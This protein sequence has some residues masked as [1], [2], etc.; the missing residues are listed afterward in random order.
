MVPLVQGEGQTIPNNPQPPSRDY[1][2]QDGGSD[3]RFFE[4]RSMWLEGYQIVNISEIEKVVELARRHNYNCLSPLIN[5]DYYGVYYNSKYEP[6]HVDVAWNFDPLMELIQE[7]HKYGIAVMPWFHTMINPIALRDNPEWGAVHESGYRSIYWMNPALPQVK[8][9]LGNTTRELF[10][11]Y[12]LDGIKI[13]TIRYPNGQYSYDDYSLRIYVDEG[14]DD[15][16]AFRREQITKIMK[17]INGN[18]TEMRPWAWIGADIFSN[19]NSR[20]YGVFQDAYGWSRDGLIDFATPMIYTTSVS[21]YR[22]TLEHNIQTLLCP[23][24]GGTYVYVPGNSAHGYVPDE[25][26]G[27]SILENQTRAARD[28]DALGTC[29]FAYKFLRQNITYPRALSGSVFSDEA[30]CPLKEQEHPVDTTRWDFDNDHDREGWRT[31]NM[32]HFYPSEEVWSVS[33]VKA[34]TFMTPLMN[35]SAPGTNVI[36]ISMKTESDGGEVE[37]YWSPVNTNFSETRRINFTLESDGDWNLYSIHLDRSRNW[38]GLIKY[39]MIRP[40]F[41]ERTNLT[42]DFI[43]LTWMPDCIQSVSYLGPFTTGN[44]SSLMTT[45]FVGGEEDLDPLKDQVVG[46]RAWRLYD[47]GRDRIDMRFPLG[48]LSYSVTY[49]HLFLLAS[50]TRILEARTGSSDGMIM[51]INGEEVVRNSQPRRVAPDQNTTRVRIDEGINRVLVKLCVYENDNSVFMRFTEPG[52]IT[53]EG[54]VYIPDAKPPD[55]PRIGGYSDTWDRDGDL[56]ISLDNPQSVIPF[57]RYQWRIDMA[58]LNDLSEKQLHLNDLETGVHLLEVRSVNSLGIHSNFSSCEIFVDRVVPV[59]T[60]PEPEKER[61]IGGAISWNW[62]LERNPPSGI[63]QMEF[64]VMYRL[65]EDDPYSERVYYSKHY[66]D[67]FVLSDNLRDGFTYQL[68]VNIETNSGNS[69]SVRSVTKTLVDTCPPR[70]T[71]NPEILLTDPENRVYRVTWD[72][73]FDDVDGVVKCYQVWTRRSGDY[74]RYHTT[75]SLAEVEVVRPLY[76]ILDVKIRAVDKGGLN[77]MFSDTVTTPLVK[78]DPVIDIEGMTIEGYPLE[79]RSRR[80]SDPDG[81]ITSTKWYLNGRWISSD[82]SVMLNLPKGN[83]TISLRVEDDHGLSEN[84]SRVL[85]VGCSGDEPYNGSLRTYLNEK[86][87]KDEYLPPQEVYHYHNVTIPT[88]EETGF[89]REGGPAKVAVMSLVSI[90]IVMISALALLLLLVFIRSESLHEKDGVKEDESGRGPSKI[91]QYSKQKSSGLRY[92]GKGRKRSELSPSRNDNEEEPV[93]WE[94]VN[95]EDEEVDF[96]L[97]EDDIR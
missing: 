73:V 72:Y 27:I 3:E 7:A 93:E 12:P 78:P 82:P 81:I 6:K 77:G 69:Y 51:W 96:V 1:P 84:V 25:E 62:E 5:G 19:Y 24:V 18:I 58:G 10:Y 30:L 86:H 22:A 83:H 76:S 67:S 79:I 17:V 15:P 40:L 68:R 55:P 34:P 48:P 42:L 91:P 90:A 46:G 50:D 33:N 53:A 85:T 8:N 88:E 37:I 28:L 95:V 32:G 70:K 47:M 89:L 44:G 31:T 60:A 43:E 9:Y 11:R 75:V 87:V 49:L 64:T 23:V 2:Q 94:E 39:I 45:D 21:S 66:R 71:T 16:D 57:D 65:N 36:E 35:I 13:D 97:E 63:Y 20:Q 52:N 29:Q 61:Y 14:W 4:Y 26:T 80:S 54:L 56:T 92:I 59:I 41:P 38:V 74:W